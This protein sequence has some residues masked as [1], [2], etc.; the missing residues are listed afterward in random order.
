MGEEVVRA[1]IGLAA[2]GHAAATRYGLDLASAIPHDH[3]H[4]AS[5]SLADRSAAGPAGATPAAAVANATGHPTDK[6]VPTE[7]DRLIESLG[8]RARSRPA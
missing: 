5:A 7:A 3:V 1:M 4:S 8:V 6:P 2:G